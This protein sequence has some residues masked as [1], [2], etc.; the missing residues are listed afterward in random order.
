MKQSFNRALTVFLIFLVLFLSNF[1]MALAKKNAN[2]SLKKK[3]PE[4]LRLEKLQQDEILRKEIM[5]FVKAHPERE[6]GEGWLYLARQYR[7]L[8]EPDRSLMYLVCRH[9]QRR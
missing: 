7:E 1:S 3:S 2:L 8:K 4:E 6:K 5:S 9:P